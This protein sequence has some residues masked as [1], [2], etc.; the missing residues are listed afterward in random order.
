MLLLLFSEK[1]TWGAYRYFRA[2]IIH[3]ARKGLE[4]DAPV[5]DIFGH[6]CAGNPTHA[7]INIT[8]I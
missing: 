7:T 8:V 1:F 6:G 2:Q 5:I 4:M 3:S